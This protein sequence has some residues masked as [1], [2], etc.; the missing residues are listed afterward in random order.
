MKP[1]ANAYNVVKASE[2]LRLSAYPD[3]GTGGEPYTIGYGSTHGV[4]KG[5]TIT[6][7]EASAR[8]VEDMTEA[9]DAVNRLVTVKLNQNQFDALCSL[10]FNIGQA[11]FRGSTLLKLL[12]QGD[13][14]G[15]AKEFDRWVYA[16][17]KKL[18]GLVARRKLE[19][20][21]FERPV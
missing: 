15:A 16:A 21:L 2:G 12:N 5:M 18:P 4:T 13:F 6:P 14:A 1:S 11:N 17:K 19:R 20:D 8:L 7:D 9:A 10:A 3:P